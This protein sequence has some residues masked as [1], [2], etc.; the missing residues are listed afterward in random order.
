MLKKVSAFTFL[1]L[2]LTSLLTSCEPGGDDGPKANGGNY[3]WGASGLSIEKVKSKMNMVPAISAKP[4]S[5]DG[6]IY[7]SRT[8]HYEEPACHGRPAFWSDHFEIAAD[9][10]SV[11]RS[12]LQKIVAMAE[13][14]LEMFAG[15]L[16]LNNTDL[17]TVA[18][19]GRIG[20]CVLNRT[21]S[22]GSGH[23]SAL[24][25]SAYNSNADNGFSY[26]YTLHKHELMHILDSQFNHNEHGFN[27]TPGWWV[28]GLAELSSGA[29]ILSAKQWASYHSKYA[30]SRNIV[31][32]GQAESG[33]YN[34]YPLYTTIVAY[35]QSQGLGTS[36]FK[37]F[38]QTDRWH[39]LDTI[40]TAPCPSDRFFTGACVA[41]ANVMNNFEYQF[42][43]ILNS[44]T[45]PLS[46]YGEFETSYYN[47]VLNWLQN[48]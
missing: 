4:S 45:S 3:G 1:L 20:I 8:Q 47:L 9:S 24:V 26:E 25:V 19:G 13:V 16:N 36:G 23:G 37:L 39:G 14:N 29:P 6:G 34:A 7:I 2:I 28:E 5:T 18:Y 22:H 11:P 46:S 48:R 27:V 41:P 32:D 30:P 21:S 12:I 42:N 40:D 43:D 15:H 44:S 31:A 10:D 38:M 33:S 17:I 35:L